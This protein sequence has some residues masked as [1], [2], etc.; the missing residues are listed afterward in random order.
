VLIAKRTAGGKQEAAAPWLFGATILSSACLLFLV[1]PLA[2]KLI[3]PVFGGSSS[4][5][6][7]CL[8]FFQVGLLLG[9]LYAHGVASRLRSKWQSRV[10]IAALIASVM[11]LP[12]LPDPRWHPRPGYDPAWSIFG[13]L[14]T[15]VGL[16]YLMLSTTSPLLQSWFSRERKGELPYHYFA[17][18][19]LGSMV[20]LFSFPFLIE[21]NFTRHQQ[22][23]GWSIAYAMF[24]GLCAVVAWKTQRTEIE[25]ERVAEPSSSSVADIVF[26]TALPATA[27][28]LLMVTTS[29]ITENIAPMPMVWILPLGIYLLSFILC[30]AP[31][32]FY[33][34]PL[35]LPLLIGAMAAYAA[36][37]GPLRH[38]QIY[39]SIPLL[40]A[41][42]FVCCMVMHGEVSRQKPDPNKLTTFYLCLSA[43]GALGGALIGLVAPH[44]FKA[45]NEYVLLLV[46]VPV[47]A[48]AA[49]LRGH[50]EWARPGLMYASLTLGL[51][52]SLTI[53]GY[54]AQQFW[55]DLRDTKLLARN[56]YG[57]VQVYPATDT[58]FPALILSHGVTIHGLQFSAWNL[59]RQPT[60]YYSRH[61]GA[62]LTFDVLSAKGP[63]KLGVIGLGTGTMAAYGRKGDVIRYYEI[64][65]K[66]IQI[67]NTQFTYL[68]D[69][70]AKIDVIEGDARLMLAAEPDQQFDML[71]VDAFSS[72][73][74]P[75][76]LLTREAFQLYWRHLKPDGVLAMHVS[77]HYLDLGPVVELGNKDMGKE[78]W[79][80]LCTEN[81][82]QDTEPYNSTYILVSSRKD[83]FT[84][85]QFDQRLS[86]ITMPARLKMWTDEYTTLWPIF[87]VKGDL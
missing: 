25:V 47:V 53:A 14:A 76:H 72:D 43:G 55:E 30:F 7:T 63:M 35:Y 86:T 75:T 13:L 57:S 29:M 16:P 5:W 15:S 9:Y 20:A 49:L 24:V 56:F 74:I 58:D 34:R 82:P 46:V 19:N 71:V 41:A 1:Q 69:S 11:A 4:I 78:I 77:N 37:I 60:T 68:A 45:M 21:P 66:I 65:P 59:R 27:S 70:A 3:L 84:A 44:V 62:G 81:E 67:A 31:R 52:A 10:H 48:L 61:S 79:Q 85:K 87:H 32:N 36:C 8:L 17:I 54:A 28:V 23:W 6:I 64:D 80:V 40:C 18:S 42:L 12:I 38:E 39:L 83:F 51:V 2:S 50:R 26:W 73:A 33:W 22:A